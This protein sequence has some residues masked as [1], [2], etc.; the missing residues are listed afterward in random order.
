MRAVTALTPLRSPGQAGGRLSEI[1][2]AIADGRQQSVVH[3]QFVSRPHAKIDLT[4]P[5]IQAAAC[6]A[7]GQRSIS[8]TRISAASCL[9]SA[10]PAARRFI[11][12]TPTTA[13]AN[14]NSRSGRPMSCTLDQARRK[15]RLDAGAGA[16]RRGSAAQRRELRATPTLKE[17]VHDRYLPY[18]KSYKR[19]WCTDETVLRLHILPH[20]GAQ[21]VDQLKNEQIADLLQAHARPGLCVRHDQPR[22]DPVALH[23]QSR[24]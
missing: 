18:V 10:P 17:F 22:A 19:S 16:G 1:L 4:R 11:S 21:P 9:R 5:F 20:L 15:A 6:P 24:P 8:S 13:A 14:G 2:P 23:L 7:G 3:V 12:A